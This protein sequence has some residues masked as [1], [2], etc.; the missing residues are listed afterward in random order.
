MN[1]ETWERVGLLIAKRLAE[2]QELAEFYGIDSLHV[3]I[4]G[5]NLVTRKAEAFYVT[6]KLGE[7]GR[8]RVKYDGKMIYDRLQIREPNRMDLEEWWRRHNGT[9]T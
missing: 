6:D 9:N 3:S 8:I 5:S 7:D 4:P 1:E 2:L